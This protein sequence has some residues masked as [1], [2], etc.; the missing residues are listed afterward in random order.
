M[1]MMIQVISSCTK[2]QIEQ[3]NQTELLRNVLLHNIT[4]SGQPT[5]KT[6]LSSNCFYL[7]NIGGLPAAAASNLTNTR[8]LP[9]AQQEESSSVPKLLQCIL[10]ATHSSPDMPPPLNHEP[11]TSRRLTPSVSKIHSSSVLKPVGAFLSGVMRLPERMNT[12]LIPGTP[13]TQRHA[14]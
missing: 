4:S 3:P 7:E 9:A 6:T 8:R 11:L 10:L 12:L 1:S 14:I 13:C 5:A 2:R